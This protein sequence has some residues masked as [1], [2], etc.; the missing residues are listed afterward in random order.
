[1]GRVSVQ[2]TLDLCLSGVR[3][4][5]SGS[6]LAIALLESKAVLGRSLYSG[7]SSSDVGI[8]V[9]VSARRAKLAVAFLECE[10]N[11]ATGRTRGS[12]ESS[13]AAADSATSGTSSASSVRE[14]AVVTV[15]AISA[16]KGVAHAST[17]R[18]NWGALRGLA[19]HH[20]V[21]KLTGCSAVARALL[22]GVTSS[23]LS[24]F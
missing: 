2:G 19:I 15:L 16:L 12:S 22:E 13:S 7:G 1:M 14:L 20:D 21:I 23:S 6:V 18:S 10:A 17:R 11:I 24:H 5:A 3:K 4:L 8:G 9:G